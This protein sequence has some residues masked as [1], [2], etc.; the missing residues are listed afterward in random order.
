MKGKAAMQGFQYVTGT[1][2]LEGQGGSASLPIRGLSSLRCT[3]DVP[4]C[5]VFDVSFCLDISF[6]QMDKICA[7]CWYSALFGAGQGAVICGG[8]LL[9]FRIHLPSLQHLPAAATR[10]Q[11]YSQSLV[12]GT[13]HCRTTP[14][15]VHRYCTLLLLFCSNKASFKQARKIT[16][17][18]FMTQSTDELYRGYP[19]R[20]L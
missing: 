15:P 2:L 17:T 10:Y 20:V 1:V 19:Q 6:L 11:G 16:R 9:C 7:Q 4:I 18:T 3:G 14:V 5:F 8:D 13:S 12:L